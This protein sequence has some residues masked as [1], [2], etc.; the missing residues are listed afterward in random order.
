MLE[1]KQSYNGVIGGENV[2]A[3]LGKHFSHIYTKL[4]PI[5]FQ[6]TSNETRGETH[7]CRRGL[8]K[9]LGLNGRCIYSSRLHFLAEVSQFCVAGRIPPI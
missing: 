2:Q 5:Q 3:R 4:P 9:K 1:R 7:Y 8:I 6:L